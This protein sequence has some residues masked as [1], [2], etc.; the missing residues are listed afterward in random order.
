MEEDAVMVGC[1]FQV[2]SKNAR[3]AGSAG[4]MA[5]AVHAVADVPLADDR[6]SENLTPASAG[7]ASL[8]MTNS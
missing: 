5:V 8:P 4:S 6:W 1:T 7:V 2:R 3:E